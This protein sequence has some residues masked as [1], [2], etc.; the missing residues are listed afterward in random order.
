MGFS[1][2][3]GFLNYILNGQIIQ[4]TITT[5]N[6]NASESFD[7]K[8]GRADNLWLGNMSNVLLYNRILSTSEILQNYQAQFP[9]FLGK[10][11][12][13]NGLVNYLDAGYNVSYPGT[14]TTWN[15]ISGVS[16][17]TGTLTNGVAYSG[18]NG[19]Y[20]D[21]DGTNDFVGIPYD[22][23]WDNNV[24]GNATNFTISCW[25]KCDNF[26]NWACLIQ[27]APDVNGFYSASE[28][29]SLWVS[30]DGFQGAFGNG[31]S[32]NP[33]GYGNILSLIHI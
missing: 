24:F 22:S 16:G 12:V 5:G 1:V 15:N 17:G 20:F 33:S 23:Y 18:S 25:A 11:I 28:G 9:R 10:N 4:S 6:F 2:G 7:I 31:V 13:M 14:G 29:A 19:G 30:S 27:K 26:F 8:I 32:G 21:F 3:N